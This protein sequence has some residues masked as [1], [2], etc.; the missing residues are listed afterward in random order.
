MDLA[1]FGSFKLED[2]LGWKW[3]VVQAGPAE[4]NCRR[5]MGLRN[6]RNLIDRQVPWQMRLVMEEDLQADLETIKHLGDNAR[7]DINDTSPLRC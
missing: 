6:V 3:K 7:R 4:K 1:I 2:G 5:E